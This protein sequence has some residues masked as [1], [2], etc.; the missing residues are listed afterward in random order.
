[1]NLAKMFLNGG[2]IRSKDSKKSITVAEIKH[3]TSKCIKEDNYLLKNEEHKR[4]LELFENPFVMSIQYNV[5]WLSA[6][7]GEHQNIPFNDE[8]YGKR[9][10]K[11]TYFALFVG[12]ITPKVAQSLSLNK[13]IPPRSILKI[14]I[15]ER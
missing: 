9:L 12:K 4:I 15:E 3:E 11:E 5:E 10:K 14:P 7:R 1:M 6:S 13:V 8:L 2:Y